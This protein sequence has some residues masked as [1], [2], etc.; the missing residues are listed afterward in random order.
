M[1]LHSCAKDTVQDSFTT[2]RALNR[3]VSCIS[4]ILSMQNPLLFSLYILAP[5][6]ATMQPNYMPRCHL[7]PVWLCQHNSGESYSR[8]YLI[9][10]ALFPYNTISFIHAMHGHSFIV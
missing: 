10:P 2:L 1:S 6:M 3:C 7:L 5:I 4:D 9:S 8:T